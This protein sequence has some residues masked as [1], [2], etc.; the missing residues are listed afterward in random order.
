MSKKFLIA[1]YIIIISS[2]FFCWCMDNDEKKNSS[3]ELSHLYGK[4]C[5]VQIAHEIYSVDTLTNQ[6]KQTVEIKE[7]KPPITRT[8]A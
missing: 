2:H 3:K 8:L 1:L 6:K 7:K 5:N 4:R